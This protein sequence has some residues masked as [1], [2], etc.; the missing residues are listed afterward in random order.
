MMNSTRIGPTDGTWPPAAKR[1]IGENI[2]IANIKIFLLFIVM[3]NLKYFFIYPIDVK[4][5]K[6]LKDDK[7]EIFLDRI[8]IN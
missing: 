7:I 4:R 6:I 8:S 2:L 3:S 5:L 1:Q